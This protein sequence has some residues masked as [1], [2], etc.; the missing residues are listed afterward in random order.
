MPERKRWGNCGWSAVV[1]QLAVAAAGRSQTAGIPAQDE[2]RLEIYGFVMTDF[3]YNIDQINPDWFDV[4]RPT[5][6]PSFHDEFGRNGNTFAGVRQTRNGVKAYID[7][8]KGQLKIIFEWYL[9]GVGVNAGQTT[10]RLR[11]AYAE[12][13]HFGAG[14]TWS[15]FMDV[16]VLP[17][18]LD[19]WGPSGMAF[20]RNVQVRWAPIQSEKTNLTI[21]LE[22]PGSTQDFGVFADR[23]EERNVNARFRF[24]DLSGAFKKS[25]QRVYLR[26]AALVRNTNL[27]DSLPDAFNFDQSVTGWGVNAST[28]IKVGG[29]G[30]I[31][32]A[33]VFG[34]G[35]ENYIWDAPADI[36]TEPN[37]GNITTPVKGVPLPFRGIVSFYDHYWNDRWSSSIGYSQI[38]ITNTIFQIPSEFRKGDYA[39]ANLLYYP[40]NNVMLGGEFQWGR[41]AN[42]SD[43]FRVNDYKVQFSFKFDYSAKIAVR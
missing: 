15:P 25:G 5:K 36:A 40:A 10:F 20:F 2:Q 32:A 38:R 39:L 31:K 11:H 35:V 6:L 1:L 8:S 16:D 24:P 13:G 12:L 37:P 27:D 42:F 19:A 21:A 9:L 30:V 41:R 33:Y 7:T 14:Q 22:R 34:K 26:V 4:M 43:G 23:I 18:S 29:K 17:N 28:N 3:G